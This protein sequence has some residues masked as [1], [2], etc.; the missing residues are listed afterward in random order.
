MDDQDLHS[1]V[2]ADSHLQKGELLQ[3]SG[4]R[5]V[6]G[7]P[8]PFQ[9]R[10]ENT[11]TVHFVN[12]WF[13]TDGQSCTT[14]EQDMVVTISRG[15]SDTGECCWLYNGLPWLKYCNDTP[16]GSWSWSHDDSFT[17]NGCGFDGSYNHSHQEGTVDISP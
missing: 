6:Q 15:H 9:I 11:G 17:I 14:N 4:K 12:H 7:G 5:F 13:T 16:A 8:V 10:F 1:N 3:F 2:L